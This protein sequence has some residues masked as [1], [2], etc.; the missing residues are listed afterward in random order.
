MY[1]YIFI[2][3]SS[4]RTVIK[5][6]FVNFDATPVSSESYFLAYGCYDTCVLTGVKT[7]MQFCIFH[8]SLPL[9]MFYEYL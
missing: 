2:K 4:I 3:V 6:G 1:K 7:S 5:I 8:F 9:L